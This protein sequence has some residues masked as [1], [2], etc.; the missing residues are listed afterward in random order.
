MALL[1]LLIALSGPTPVDRIVAVVG[2]RPVLHSDVV[3]ELNAG[4]LTEGRNRGADPGSEEY[5]EALDELVGRLLL[6]EAAEESA[7]YPSEAEIAEMAEARLDSIRAEFE[8]EDAFTLA[9]RDY[10]LTFEG[11]TERARRLMSDQIAISTIMGRRVGSAF[12]AIPSNT[13]GYLDSHRAMLEEI[14]MPRHLRW[15][16]LPVLPDSETYAPLVDS[17]GEVRRRIVA[18]DVSFQSCAMEMS[19]D[20]S[21]ERGGDLGYFGTGEMTPMFEA[22]VCTLEVGEISN[23]VVTQYGVHL[24][25]LLDRRSADSAALEEPAA[26]QFL[27]PAMLRSNEQV[28]ARHILFRL[29]ADRND[30]QRTVA[31]AES[32][33]EEIRS[34]LDFPRAAERYSEDPSTAETGGDLGTVLIGAWLPEVAEELEGL[35][36]GAVSEPVVVSEGLAVALFEVLGCEGEIDWSG[37]PDSYL[38]NLA[39]SVAYELE[40][41]EVV[42]SLRHEIPVVIYSNEG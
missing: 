24:I 22:A 31:G 15:I 3:R 16:Y 23:P 36:P 12:R 39:R 32:I 1:I 38:Q 42:D 25:E 30:L 33:L 10:G 4:V 11:Y 37:Y 41:R 13:A 8:S 14:A 35:P 40:Y 9:L 26:G 6:V 28:R 29:R 5:L 34:G 27:S 2:D 17:L 7:L 20:R 19:E 18:G 21:A